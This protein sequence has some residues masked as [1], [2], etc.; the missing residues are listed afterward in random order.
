[1]VAQKCHTIPKPMGTKIA[2]INF[3]GFSQIP[4]EVLASNC[5]AGLYANN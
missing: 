3:A 5:Y 2:Q 4:V 1:M